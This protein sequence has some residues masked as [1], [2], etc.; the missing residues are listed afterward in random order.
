MNNESKSEI[1]KIDKDNFEN[2]YYRIRAIARII[3]SPQ[4]YFANSPNVIVML[5]DIL[6]FVQEIKG[7]DK[8]YIILKS[9]PPEKWV[10]MPCEWCPT[11][12][13]RILKWREDR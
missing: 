12:I 3:R 5:E 2:I 4:I 11:G 1:E 8:F 10:E 9:D 13:D 6:K 7:N